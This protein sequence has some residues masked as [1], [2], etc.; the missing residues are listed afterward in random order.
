MALTNEQLL[1]LYERVVFARVCEDKLVQG[2]RRGLI[3]TWVH[4]GQG[5]EANA[6]AA[7]YALRPDDYA[8]VPHRP[9]VSSYYFK[10]ADLN[11]IMAEVLGKKT[12]ICKGKGGIMHMADFEHGLM[13]ALGMIGYNL[14][15]AT[16]VALAAKIRRED[17]VVLNIFGDGA[18]G[19]GTFQ[20]SLTMAST[21]KLPIVFFCVNNQFQINVR[22][23]DVFPVRIGDR[24]P[25]F[26]IP[27]VTIDGND[28]IAVYETTKVAV[29]RARRGEGPSLI[30][31]V[32][33]RW[34]EHAEGL[35]RVSAPSPRPYR[36]EEEK[37][38]EEKKDPV[39][40]F[41]GELV[42]RGLLTQAKIDEVNSRV[43]KLLDDAIEF[44]RSS[45][46]PAAEEVYEDVF[47]T[48]L[49]A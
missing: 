5:E 11:K 41:Q 44:A 9:Q 48:R 27:G 34:R 7:L 29:D 12:G 40:R 18:S 21:G 45:P 8:V 38:R 10:G 20:E 32:C 6:A 37:T 1:E 49:S 46:L 26:G 14:P 33:W 24:A 30:E 28:V 2:F 19:Q 15:L 43:S 35:E 23:G 16:G 4:P 31:S 36:T 47:S 42:S 39:A 22:A 3:T 17:R 13:G 25:A